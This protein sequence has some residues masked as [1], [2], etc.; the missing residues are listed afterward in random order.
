MNRRLI[1]VIITGLIIEILCAVI[2]YIGDIKKNIPC[3]AF[4]YTASFIAYIFAVFYVLKN[5]GIPAEDENKTAR[6][7]EEKPT[8]GGNGL[9]PSS[10]PRARPNGFIG[11]EGWNEAEAVNSNRNSLDIEQLHENGSRKILWVIIIFSLMFRFTLLPMTPSDDM[12]RYLWEG[13]LQ[14]NGINPYSHP[15][16]SPR[17]LHLRDKFFS[18][19]N[20][21]SLSTIY[22]PLML[23]AFAAADYISYSFLSM[24]TL[25]LL[26]DVFSIFLLLR[27]LSAMG[28]ESVNVL[29]YAWSP[30]VLMSFAARGH[31]DSLQIFLAILALYFFATGK[32]L[33]SAISIGLAVM[34]KFIYVIF[35]PFLI[36]ALAPGKRL[37]YVTILFSVIAVLYLPYVGAGKGLFATLFH[38]GTEYHFNDSVHFL[39]FCLCLGSPLASKI[40]TAA[41]FGAAL[42]YLYKKYLNLLITDDNGDIPQSSLSKEGFREIN[43]AV[44]KFAFLSI[45]AFLILTPTLHPW[46]LTWIVPFLCFNKNRAWLVLTG[47]VVFYYFMNYPLFSKLIEYNNEWVWQEVHWLKLPEYLPFYFLLLYGFLRKHLFT[48]ERNHPVLQN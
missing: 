26:F 5:S 16:E 46:Y 24:K 8:R 4:L 32:S 21:K 9:L 14:L 10:P 20:H 42:L 1:V 12:Y 34:S 2:A 6:C 18:G 15:P 30:L 40:I 3:F 41:I 48:D 19:I 47:T 44:L 29:I 27:F 39:I 31:G 36:S 22:P 37:K 33:K 45:G 25:F 13:K 38:F 43:D 17:L 23:M 28:K 35:T 7:Q 11:R